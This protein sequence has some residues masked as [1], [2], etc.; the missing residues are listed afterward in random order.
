MSKGLAHP[1]KKASLD[2]CRNF[3]YGG[4][5]KGKELTYVHFASRWS[6][7]DYPESG[8][9]AGSFNGFFSQILFLFC[10]SRSK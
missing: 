7:M 4:E 8:L 10:F 2:D 9:G 6:E 3:F 5:G 1:S